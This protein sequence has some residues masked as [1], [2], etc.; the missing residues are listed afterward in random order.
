MKDLK[1]TLELFVGVLKNADT[2][3][4]SKKLEAAES[5]QELLEATD[6]GELDFDASIFTELTA[7]DQ[8]Y[9]IVLAALGCIAFS[10]L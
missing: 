7:E 5:A 8:R 10:A 1:H 4:A 6:A 9:I 2:I 3:K